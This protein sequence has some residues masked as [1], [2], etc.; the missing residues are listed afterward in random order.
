[1]CS[2]DWSSDVCSS[3][4]SN[5]ILSVTVVLF[6]S[7]LQRITHR[8][9]KL[10]GIRFLILWQIHCRM[11]MVA[12]RTL[13][14]FVVVLIAAT[15]YPVTCFHEAAPRRSA[16]VSERLPLRDSTTILFAESSTGTT[17][18]VPYST[19]DKGSFASFNYNSYWYPVVWAEDLRLKKPTKITL[20]D[21]DYVVAKL[22][23]TEVICLK[24]RCP[25]KSAALSEGRIT[26]A[27]KFQCAYH[28]WSFDGTDGSCEEIPQIGRAHV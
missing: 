10:Y 24:D 25:H 14:R 17:N 13:R 28:G 22:S 16:A 1:M 3:D 20:F 7:N 5:G 19:G 9:E 26:A 23:E 18:S 4:L 8:T 2:C 21:V 15:L 11:T 27:G 12:T 6:H